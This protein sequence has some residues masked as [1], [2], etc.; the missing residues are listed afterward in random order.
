MRIVRYLRHEFRHDPAPREAP[1]HVFVFDVPHLAPC[2]VFPPLHLLN[3]K[4]ATGGGD[5]GM[6][7]GA[8]WVPFAIDA[9]EYEALLS[10]ILAADRDEIAQGARFWQQTFIRDASFDRY[11]DWT[12][13]MFAVCAKHRVRRA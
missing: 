1:L 9:A 13:W 7:P 8:S 6:S 4:L 12:A 3:A 5:A 10:R 2:G 11:D